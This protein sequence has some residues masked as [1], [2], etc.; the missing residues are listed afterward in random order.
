MKEQKADPRIH[1]RALEKTEEELLK[2]LQPKEKEIRQLI[3]ELKALRELIKATAKQVENFDVDS[4]TTKDNTSKETIETLEEVVA[5]S[6][7]ERNNT[8]TQNNT[9]GQYASVNAKQL[10][11]ASNFQTIDELYNLAYKSN[12]S[13]E[14]AKKFFDI[15][16]AIKQTRNY[17]NEISDIFKERVDNTYQALQQV[18]EKAQDQIK[19]NYTIQQEKIQQ[20][21]QQMQ[22]RIQP[23]QEYKASTFKA[24][25]A[26][27][28]QES[29][30]P[31]KK[32]LLDDKL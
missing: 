16:Y 17:E 19:E 24:P 25:Q 11:I 3:E 12:W 2:K 31:Q 13:T 15:Q 7:Q 5:Q 29:Y 23:T 22:A 32:I 4:Q 8:K 1:L 28:I 18:W 30:K 10:T 14:D 6:S 26:P 9:S 20:N 27:Q 21:Q